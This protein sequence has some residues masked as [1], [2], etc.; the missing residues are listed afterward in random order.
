MYCPLDYHEM[1]MT[2]FHY[3]VIL[4]FVI[5]HWFFPFRC[6]FSVILFFSL[7]LF[8]SRSLLFIV[9]IVLVYI[10][11]F[12]V[13]PI[14]PCI[15]LL[16]F[17]NKDYPTTFTRYGKPLL[18]EISHLFSKLGPDRVVWPT[19]ILEAEAISYIPVREP[20]NWWRSWA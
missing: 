18:R 14:F 4:F 13:F 1:R 17:I 2:Y 12:S 11:C 7:I 16:I 3:C 9:T 6:I 5:T 10:G 20:H 15:L 19:F 8:F